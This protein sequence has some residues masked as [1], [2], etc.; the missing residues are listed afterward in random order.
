MPAKSILWL[1]DRS[2]SL[3]TIGVR[4]FLLALRHFEHVRSWL[5]YL[6][7]HDSWY[8]FSTMVATI[9]V[10][11]TICESGCVKRTGL[12]EE[13]SSALQL[14]RLNNLF[15][16]VNAGRR[17]WGA[18]NFLF[19]MASSMV[20]VVIKVFRCARDVCRECVSIYRA[21]LV[22]FA[23]RTLCSIWSTCSCLGGRC[24][25]PEL[26]FITF[27]SRSLRSMIVW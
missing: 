19:G 22:T 23:A 7:R 1:R 20:Q 15:G 10:H 5:G 12:F 24:I 14:P 9:I 17:C 13:A 6:S 16:L 8:S 11:L 3:L 2:S 25:I 27:S 18:F 4:D 21:E 26:M